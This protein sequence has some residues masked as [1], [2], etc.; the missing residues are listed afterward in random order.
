MLLVLFAFKMKGE[1]RE[2]LRKQIQYSKVGYVYS[3]AAVS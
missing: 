2:K 3:E 1:M